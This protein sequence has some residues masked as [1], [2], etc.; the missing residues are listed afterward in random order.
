MSA[1]G[2]EC[3]I[4]TTGYTES[5]EHPNIRCQYS[6]K[7]LGD[8]G[9]D[10][11]YYCSNRQIPDPAGSLDP[12]TIM[13]PGV[14]VTE[15]HGGNNQSIQITT[16]NDEYEANPKSTNFTDSIQTPYF[17]N[18]KQYTKAVI[19]AEPSITFNAQDGR[20]ELSSFHSPHKIGTYFATGDP[21]PA[22]WGAWKFSGEAELLQDKTWG[23]SS[24]EV[25]ADPYYPWETSLYDPVAEERQH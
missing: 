17:K 15:A 20:F 3:M 1:I 21:A 9:K 25:A 12:P 10:L 14:G 2:N 23:L 24:A 16:G 13:G 6:T 5:T 11:Y 22:N 18:N 7:V 8:N 19:G 4:P